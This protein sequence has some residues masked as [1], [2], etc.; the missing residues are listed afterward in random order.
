MV[1]MSMSELQPISTG[2]EL[3]EMFRTSTQTPKDMLHCGQRRVVRA[4]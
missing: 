3:F 2:R 1:I 4:F